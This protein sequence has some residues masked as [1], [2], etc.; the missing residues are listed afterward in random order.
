MK[1]PQ[2]RSSKMAFEE[3]PLCVTTRMSFETLGSELQRGGSW[4][5]RQVNGKRGSREGRR[6]RRSIVKGRRDNKSWRGMQRQDRMRVWVS[7]CAGGSAL[8]QRRD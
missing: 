4:R 6:R 1:T 2:E 3:L 7:G 8:I 5:M